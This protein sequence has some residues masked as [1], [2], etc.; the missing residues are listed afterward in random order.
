MN[1]QIPFMTED[2]LGRKVNENAEAIALLRDVVS[3][4]GKTV[5]NMADMLKALGEIRDKNTRDIRALNAQNREVN[6]D[7]KALLIEI[8]QEMSNGHS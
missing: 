1:D 2:N 7:I 5:S 3:I 8:R 4:Q 6:E